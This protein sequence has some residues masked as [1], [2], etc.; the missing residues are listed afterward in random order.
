M[1]WREKHEEYELAVLWT[2]E[3]KVGSSF[4]ESSSIVVGDVE[5]VDDVEVVNQV[6]NYDHWLAAEPAEYRGGIVL[7][8]SNS[9][10]LLPVGLR[11]TWV[12]TSWTVLGDCIAKALDKQGVTE[13]ERFLAK[14]VLGFIRNYLWRASEMETTKVGFDDIALLRAFAAYGLEA[15]K[16]IDGLV[17]GLRHVVAEFGFESDSFAHMKAL[18]KP[19]GVSVLYTNIIDKSISSYPELYVGVSGA[20]AE[21]W[22]QTAPTNVLKRTIVESC[23][24]SIA[25]TESAKF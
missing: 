12:C 24:G 18:Y 6:T 14:H 19:S 25:C 5:I 10:H 11:C 3:V 22:L 1:G 17:A 15:E 9:A 13:S 16:K 21:L 8:L 7:S 20:N 2:I 23:S 4:H